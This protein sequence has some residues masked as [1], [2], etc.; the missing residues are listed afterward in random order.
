MPTLWNEFN[1]IYFNVEKKWGTPNSCTIVNKSCNHDWCH[2]GKPW[3][4]DEVYIS[5]YIEVFVHHSLVDNI[6]SFFNVFFQ[7]NIGGLFYQLDWLSK[8][9]HDQ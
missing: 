7:T 2:Q 3:I 6:F 5:Q 4:D 1:V 9:I 8:I